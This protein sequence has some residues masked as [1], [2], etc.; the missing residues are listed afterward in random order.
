M[1]RRSSGMEPIARKPRQI[2]PA[3]QYSSGSEARAAL[4]SGLTSRA[5]DGGSADGDCGTRCAGRRTDRGGALER[6]ASGRDLQADAQQVP[7]PLDRELRRVPR[8]AGLLVGDH[9]GRRPHGQP[10]LADLLLGSGRRGRGR[11]GLSDRARARDVHRHGPAQAR[12]PE[13]ALPGGLHAAA[14]RRP[15]GRDQADRAARARPPRGPRA[16]W[17]WWARSP[18]RSWRA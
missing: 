5:S 14:D 8:G 15:R 9:R 12:S 3:G 10:R 17:T 1:R 18:S 7:D 16:R 6:R 2:W 11:G 13:G 4:E